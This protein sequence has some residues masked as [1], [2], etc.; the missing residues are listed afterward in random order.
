MASVTF[1]TTVGGDGS[2]VTDDSNA[3]TGLAAGGHRT[4]FVPA[5]A[6]AVA[7]A[8]NTVTKALQAAASESN[9][10]AQAAIA[11]IKAAA[12]AVSATS[13]A[14]SASSAAGYAALLANYTDIAQPLR[15]HRRIVTADFTVPAEHNA[16]SAGPITVADGVT[17][18]VS[19]HS[20]WSIS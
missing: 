9:A 1:S 7:V 12:S 8:L 5:L 20:T 2:T 14:A 19:S 13:A 10:V 11:T 15:L 6:Q 16:M 17:V 4:R 3:G 18:T